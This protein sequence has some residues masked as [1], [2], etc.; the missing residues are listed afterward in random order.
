MIA[1][2]LS[3]EPP[4]VSDAELV[5]L[6]ESGDASAKDALCRKHLS[7][8]QGLAFRLLGRR[9]EDLDEVVQ[10][11]FVEALAGLSSLRDPAAFRAWLGSIVVNRVRLYIRRRRIA[12]NAGLSSSEGVDLELVPDDQASP[13]LALELREV[14]SCMDD[15]LEDEERWAL[16][17][18]RVEGY[19]LTE[20]AD[21]LE[22]SLATVKRRVA[23]AFEKLSAASV[24]I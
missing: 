18:H 1:A 23:S 10:D 3:L 2:V 11:T 5:L 6:A 17:L 7:M 20:V 4:T 9:S 21:Q 14:C 16:L 19:T 8:V 22:L 15:A 12:T 24:S 13:E